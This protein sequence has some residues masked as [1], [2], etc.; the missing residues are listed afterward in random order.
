M[1]AAGGVARMVP[2]E[3]SGAGGRNTLHCTLIGAGALQAV[4]AVACRRR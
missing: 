3:K 4:L 2:S 1:D